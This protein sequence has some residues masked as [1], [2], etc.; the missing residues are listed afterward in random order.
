MVGRALQ[1]LPLAKQRHV[2][3]ILHPGFIRPSGAFRMLLGLESPADV[4]RFEPEHGNLVLIQDRDG[5]GE[6]VLIETDA[7]W[8]W[9]SLNA[10]ERGR[11]IVAD[12]V[13]WTGGSGIGDRDSPLFTLMEG[14]MPDTERERPRSRVYRYVIDPGAGRLH[15]EILA[16]DSGYELPVVSPRRMCHPHRFGY[17]ARNGQADLFWSSVA[18]LDTGTGRVDA[19]DFGPGQYCSEPTFAPRPAP[20]SGEEAGW[21]LTLVY[22]GAT[23]R[24]FLAVLDAEHVADGPVARVHLTHH[25]PLSFHGTWYGEA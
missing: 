21:L 18:R 25:T 5:R 2:V 19:F 14:R 1:I 23:K 6:P 12:F 11:E 7:L 10:Y 24:S 9:H 20:S 22:D 17:F 16:D 3:L 8:K 15:R 13:G 4:I